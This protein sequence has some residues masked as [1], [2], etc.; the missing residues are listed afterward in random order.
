MIF[1]PIIIKF[2]ILNSF[3][4]VQYF[5]FVFSISFLYLIINY[6][7]IYLIFFIQSK[8]YLKLKLEGDWLQI[9]D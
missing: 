5:L 3:K 2:F 4:F 8:L 1:N 9:I 7:L 6:V